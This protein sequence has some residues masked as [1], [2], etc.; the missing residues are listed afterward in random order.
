VTEYARQEYERAI[1]RLQAFIAAHPRDGRM[2]DAR[3][4][5]GEAYFSRQ[6]YA[7]TVSEFETLIREYPDSRRIPAALYRQ[8][9]ARLALGDRSGCQLLSDVVSRY[10]QTREAGSARETLTARCP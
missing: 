7:E 10:P 9:E 4:L 5:L 8:G 3:F 6:R 1:E 2:P